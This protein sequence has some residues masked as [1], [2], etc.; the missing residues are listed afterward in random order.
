MRTLPHLP[1]RPLRANDGSVKA[2]KKI[3]LRDP[4]ALAVAADEMALLGFDDSGAQ[5]GVRRWVV[6]SMTVSFAC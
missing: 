3:K 5:S 4:A 1:P 2:E 6:V